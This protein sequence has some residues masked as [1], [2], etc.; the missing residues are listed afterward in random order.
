MPTDAQSHG[1][2]VGVH[3]ADRGAM[4]TNIIP[5]LCPSSSYSPCPPP[6][7]PP[8][9]V[10][11][12]RWMNARSR[13]GGMRRARRRR[14]KQRMRMDRESPVLLLHSADMLGDQVSREW[15]RGKGCIRRCAM[16]CHACSPN[17]KMICHA[18]GS[19]ECHAMHATSTCNA[20]PYN[21]TSFTAPPTPP[22]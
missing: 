8:C 17:I 5:T 11:R 3:N 6:H 18:R 1:D 12:R 9:P 4:Q 15:G 16:I 20:M 14:M 22:T 19:V 2:A 13:R 21:A 10:S 7:S